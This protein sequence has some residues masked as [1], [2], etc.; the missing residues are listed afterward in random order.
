[1]ADDNQPDLTPGRLDE[2][3]HALEEQLGSG[4]SSFELVVIGGSG[5][6]ALGLI[7]RATRDVDVVAL[8]QG[9][10]LSSAEPLPEAIVTAAT[11]VARDFGLSP[12]WLNS[13]PADLF[14]LGLPAGLDQR[15]VTRVIGPSLTIHFASRYDQIHFK[16]FAMVDQGSGKHELDLRALDASDDELRE[17]ARW[18]LTH[19]PSPGFRD[20]LLAVLRYLGVTDAAF[21]T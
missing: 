2:A 6:L 1:M 8:G 17:A 18:T 4:G 20:E 21:G 13:G 9:Q 7:D 15:W 3:L 16:L 12:G 5:L 14:R 19:D 11:R 10:S